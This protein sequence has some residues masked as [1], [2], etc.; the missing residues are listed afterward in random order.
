MISWELEWN[1]DFK[2]VNRLHFIKKRL[3]GSA[4]KQQLLSYF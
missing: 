3:T 4:F 1:I 2:W